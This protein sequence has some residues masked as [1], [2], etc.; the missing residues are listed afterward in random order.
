MKLSP[1]QS[2]LPVQR[3]RTELW[4][5]TGNIPVRQREWPARDS[6]TLP[7]GVGPEERGR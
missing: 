2:T 7:K 5:H 3:F 6:V 4:M 1:P